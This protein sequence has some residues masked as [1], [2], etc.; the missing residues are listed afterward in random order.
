[1]R[2]AALGV[3]DLQGE[4]EHS[5]RASLEAGFASDSERRELEQALLRSEQRDEDMFGG[6][7]E[8]NEEHMENGGGE[9]MGSGSTETVP[10]GDRVMIATPRSVGKGGTSNVAVINSSSK[11]K[12]KPAQAGTSTSTSAVTYR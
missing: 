8:E 7:N 12:P 4:L 6:E 11:P 1:M 3:S 2:Y 5:L 10:T 9:D